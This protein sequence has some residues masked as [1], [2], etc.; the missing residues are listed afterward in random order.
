MGVREDVDAAQLGTVVLLDGDADLDSE[1]RCLFDI[2]RTR[3]NISPAQHALD[4]RRNVR[5][6]GRCDGDSSQRV[7]MVEELPHRI[8]ETV[9]LFLWVNNVKRH[10]HACEKVCVLGHQPSTSIVCFQNVH[11]RRVSPTVALTSPVK[12]TTALWSL[13]T[14]EFTTLI[15]PSNELDSTHGLRSLQLTST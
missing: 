8:V 6:V 5:R 13:V 7:E 9:E 3:K 2:A 4:G 11:T 1:S 12:A 10:R 15:P 14:A